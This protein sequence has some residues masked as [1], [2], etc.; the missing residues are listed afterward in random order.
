MELGDGTFGCV[1]EYKDPET[2]RILA[3]KKNYREA[4]IGSIGVIRETEI[5]VRAKAHPNIVRL[6]SVWL[7]NA[8]DSMK[9]KQK[10]SDRNEDELHLLF[11]KAS[12]DFHTAIYELEQPLS[13]KQIKRYMFQILF[14]VEWLHRQGIIHRDLKP[15]NVLLFS[16]QKYIDGLAGVAKISDFGSAKP[17][18]NQG[19]NTPHIGSPPY[20]APE[21]AL[22]STDYDEKVDVWSL[23]CLFY[24][25][26]SR[27]ILHNNL[28]DDNDKVLVTILNSLPKKLS[29]AE[30][31]RLI[32][33]NRYRPVDLSSG[34]SKTN[35]TYRKRLETTLDIER[36]E[37]ECGS[38]DLFIDLLESMLTFD[39]TMRSTTSR[40]LHHEFFKEFHGLIEKQDSYKWVGSSD[41]VYSVDRPERKIGFAYAINHFNGL[42]NSTYEINYRILF[43]AL[44]LFDHVLHMYHDPFTE[45]EI[46]RY[47]LACFYLAFKYF[48]SSL[49]CTHF[50]DLF[51]DEQ[52][53]PHTEIFDVEKDLYY[54]WFDKKI[55][56]ATIYETADQAGDLLSV[57]DIKIMIVMITNNTKWHGQKLT[58]FYKFYKA[59]KQDQ[60]RLI[61]DGPSDFEM[62]QGAQQASSPD[63]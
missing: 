57:E 42:L 63:C 14:G 58:D 26:I 3:F 24:E 15:A 2:N 31:I 49:L 45:I 28:E 23:G 32:R 54:N 29:E 43:Q 8:P 33:N 62:C 47:Y 11:E 20:R 16:E 18:H 13:Y 25:M 34:L 9:D 39:W 17:K 22:G 52:R 1:Y 30:R 59:N 6:E 36:F 48:S 55:Y 41:L 53:H 38:I 4:S 7:G 27:T 10:Y 5:L 40:C 56:R 60:E 50:A 51:P 44:D 19:D 35:K 21:I 37:E 12:C 46:E 61:N